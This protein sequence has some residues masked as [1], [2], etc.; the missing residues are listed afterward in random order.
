[1]DTINENYGSLNFCYTEVLN[2][3]QTKISET[4]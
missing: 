1:M 2:G 4:V 3:K